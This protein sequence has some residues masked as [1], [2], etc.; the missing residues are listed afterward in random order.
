[1]K[2]FKLKAKEAREIAKED[3]EIQATLYSAVKEMKEK[4]E[5]IKE[6]KCDTHVQED[7]MSDAA[8]TNALRYTTS[9]RVYY[10]IEIGCT[11]VFN[12]V[13]A[14]ALFKVTNPFFC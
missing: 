5:R 11:L 7:K 8:K 4:V 3:A 12:S 14:Q 6:R 2:R 9:A 10:C 1:M 13:S